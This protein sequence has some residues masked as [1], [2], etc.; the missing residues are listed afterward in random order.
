MDSLVAEARRVSV[1]DLTATPRGNRS[2]V[3]HKATGASLPLL[4][5]GEIG[6]HLQ[7]SNNQLLP[8]KTEVCTHYLGHKESAG[9]D[10]VQEVPESAIK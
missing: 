9:V 1:P 2:P 7:L 4:L 3:R 6:F 8:P 10:D 5:T